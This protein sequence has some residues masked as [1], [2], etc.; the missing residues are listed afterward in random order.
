MRGA[1]ERGGWGIYAWCGVGI[2]A[3]CGAALLCAV[4]PPDGFV[5]MFGWGVV[6]AFGAG[7]G[8]P[9]NQS[10]WNAGAAHHCLGIGISASKASWQPSKPAPTPPHLGRG[11]LRGARGCTGRL[12]LPITTVV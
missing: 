9:C 1:G 6:L 7:F 3:W 12:K 10:I 8:V 4:H 11:V 2:Y 5:C